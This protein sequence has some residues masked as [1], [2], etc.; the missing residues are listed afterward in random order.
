MKLLLLITLI[1]TQYLFALVSIVPVEIGENP[2]VHGKAAASLETKRGNT[3]KDNYRASLRL[4]YDNNISY[5]TWAEI[6]AEYGKSN[7]T[8]D[9]NK[10]FLHLR[11]IH[12]IT[13]QAVRAELFAQAQDDKFKLIKRR[14]LTGAGARF[15]VFEGFKNSKFYAGIGGYYENIDY[16]DQNPSE[17]STRLNTYLAYTIKFGEDSNFAYTFYYQPLIDYFND[18]VS[19]NKAELK[20]HI[21]KKFF[22]QLKISYDFD[23]RPPFGVKKED[24]TQTTE[25]VFNF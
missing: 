16:T 18:Y 4:N 5:V 12:L 20:L 3:H 11:H 6:S 21:Y 15:Q 22:L 24:F 25:F 17:Y 2:G 8:E 1:T 7:N 14:H 19:S 9:T 13:P 23:S 10:A